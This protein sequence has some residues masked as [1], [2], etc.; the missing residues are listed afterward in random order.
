MQNVQEDPAL[1]QEVSRARWTRPIFIVGCSR[2]G[3][4][5]L[6]LLLA[7]HPAVATS[8]ETHLFSAF[9]GRLDAA[10][11]RQETSPRRVGL[12]AVLSEQEFHRLCSDFA[13]GVFDRIAARNPAAKVVVEKTPSHVLCGDL[14]LRLFP[15][16]RFIH[17][18]RDPRAVANS[19]RAAGRSWGSEW[20][21]TSVAGAALKWKSDTEA[22]RRIGTMTRNY[23]AVRYEDLAAPGGAA[24]LQDIVRWCGLAWER[25]ECDRAMQM[26]SIDRLQT[27]TQDAKVPW[28]IENE[29]HGFYRAGKT[30]SWKQELSGHQ[31]RIVE[32]LTRDLMADYGY[33]CTAPSRRKPLQ[34]SASEIADGVEC[35]TRKLVGRAFTSTRRLL[36]P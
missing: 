18:V 13:A 16:A 12:Q 26:C 19:L 34:L 33:A 8:Q 31:A 22:G 15:Q 21:P 2:S 11:K 14:I 32:Y 4:T 23:F 27:G 17:M 24:Q 9:L 10:W 1:T 6:Q 35:R 3:T 5:W 20:A 7:Q 36:V 30:D 25:R 29:P 28:A